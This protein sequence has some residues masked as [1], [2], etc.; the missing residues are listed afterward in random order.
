[1]KTRISFSLACTLTILFSSCGVSIYNETPGEFNAGSDSP[2]KLTAKVSR[3]Q[4]VRSASIHPKVIINGQSFDMA[5]SI[6]NPGIWIYDLP[7]NMWCRENYIYH[8]ETQFTTKVSS[9]VKNAAS[10]TDTTTVR[11]YGG[12]LWHS[13]QSGEQV[14]YESNELKISR[15]SN[16]A[17][18]S[19]RVTLK[20]L[21]ALKSIRVHSVS[22][23]PVSETTVAIEEAGNFYLTL[24]PNYPVVLSNCEDKLQF[25]VNHNGTPSPPNVYHTAIIKIIY[26]YSGDIGEHVNW[27]TVRGEVVANPQ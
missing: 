1:M 12:L 15:L 16:N 9:A 4:M 11:G 8:Y 18:G 13:G 17:I 20:S 14:N 21:D 26:Y 7:D 23:Q 2:Y 22:I 25:W 10:A 3:G 19:E 24:A 27:F 6:D 5:V